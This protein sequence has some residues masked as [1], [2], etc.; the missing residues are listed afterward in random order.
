MY[1][2]NTKYRNF[3]YIFIYI[4]YLI[5]HYIKLAKSVNNSIKYKYITLL[6]IFK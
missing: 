5:I 1:Y 4:N 6:H 3:F 2:M